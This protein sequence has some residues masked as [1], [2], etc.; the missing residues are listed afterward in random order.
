M[1]IYTILGPGGVATAGSGGTAIVGP[2]G[3]AITHPRSLTIAG[4]GARVYEVP[5]TT[6]L[7]KQLLALDASGVPKD[8][9]L[10]AVGPAIHYNAE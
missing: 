9:K 4:Q 10:V 6:D 1:K 2:D 8:G 7:Q 3:L 5:E